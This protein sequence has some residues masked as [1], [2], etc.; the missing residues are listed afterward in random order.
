MQFSFRRPIRGVVA[1]I[2]ALLLI[3]CGSEQS[4][5]K[6]TML[7]ASISRIEMTPRQIWAAT[8]EDFD[9]DGDDDVFI[10]GHGQRHKDRIFYYDG[11]RY[12]QGSF[13]FPYSKDRHACAGADIDLDGDLDLYCSAG[14]NR[15]R[16]KKS[17]LLFKAVGVDGEYEKVT[18]VHGAEDA[19]GRGRIVR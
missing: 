3:S 1:F 18:A 5:Q 6:T 17:N 10:G 19:Y 2:F 14:A 15:G 4:A 13:A 7:V 9:Q 11:E 12:Q 8:V 16:G